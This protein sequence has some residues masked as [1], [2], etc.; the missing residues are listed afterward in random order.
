MSKSI[1]QIGQTKDTVLLIA[2]DL[3]AFKRF[4]YGQGYTLKPCYKIAD[5]GGGVTL[6]NTAVITSYDIVDE[7][8]EYKGSSFR[9]PLY[10]EELPN[11]FD[12]AMCADAV[13]YT[14]DEFAALVDL[15]PPLPPLRKWE[16]NGRKP[17]GHI[18]W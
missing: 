4:V 7:H 1:K 12:I 6:Y 17:N 9:A 10:R 16:I 5:H 8:G 3:T 2:N 14:S 18:F 11:S 13:N 15:N